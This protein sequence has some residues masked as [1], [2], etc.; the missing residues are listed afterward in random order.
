MTVNVF[1]VQHFSTG[2]GPGIRT[3][4]FFEGCNLRCPWCHN[5][6]SF[7]DGKNPR[8]IDDIVA[9]VMS[10]DEFYKQSG[11]GV[12]LSGGEPL[13]NET[14]CLELLRR[15]KE[16]RLNTIVD[17]ALAVDGINLTEIAAYTDT[18]FV[19]VKTADGDKF[20][21]ICGGSFDTL[22]RNIGKL[23]ELGA[24]IVLRIPLIP[25]FNM[26]KE[27]TDGIIEMVRHYDLSV[28]LLPFHR[29]GSAKYKQL[30]LEYKYAGCEPS[31]EDEIEAIRQKFISYGIREANV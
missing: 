12:T 10:D 31:S 21:E 19:D 17:T 20:R 4:V 2:D 5:P 23:T 28:T 16:K 27:S 26:D 22:T 14:S 9:E 25:C 6:E 29:L 30:G 24:D 18:F 1:N 3:T 11:G 15:F 13:Y 7:Y 8:D